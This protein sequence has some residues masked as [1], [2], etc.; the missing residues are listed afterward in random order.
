M[1][2]PAAA[3]AIA[4]V[5]WVA[6]VLGGPP[7]ASAGSM[8]GDPNCDLDIN[9]L[10][11]LLVLQFD[12]GLLDTLAC[13]AAADVDKS[14][15]IDS[16]DAAIILQ[17]D[18]GLAPVVVP[19]GIVVT[20]LPFLFLG[21]PAYDC[22]VPDDITCTTLDPAW[23]AYTCTFG[24]GDVACATTSPDHPEYDCVIDVSIPCT[25]ASMDW[26]DYKCTLVISG[27]V[28]IPAQ[29]GWADYACAYIGHSLNCTTL[30]AGFP[31][32][33]CQPVGQMLQCG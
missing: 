15:G 7:G 10:D 24:E 11:A 30:E 23:P 18:A 14:G 16:I 1:V 19:L 22:L 6:V 28:C 12:A 3:A 4:L 33:S 29:P 17:L 9:S 31:D 2:R 27:F 5:L 32:F 26:P 25:T 21:N 8:P 13:E 20:V